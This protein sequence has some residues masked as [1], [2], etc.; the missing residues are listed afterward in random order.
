M[1][2]CSFFMDVPEP[3]VLKVREGER[4]NFTVLRNGS[5]DEAC[6]VQY[7][8]RD[9]KATAREGDF[10]PVEK[11]EA[12]FEVGVREQYLSIFV[13]EDGIPETDE[14]FYIVLFNSSG[15]WILFLYQV[16]ILV[17]AFS[18]IMVGTALQRWH[19]G[20]LSFVCP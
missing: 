1:L 3:R 13:H 18:K 20:A 15:D 12:L 10:V 8:T 2:T 4:A 6:T 9:G 11:G 7:V 5:L 14:P 17:G 19:Q 16:V